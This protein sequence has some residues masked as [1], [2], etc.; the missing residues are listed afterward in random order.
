MRIVQDCKA[1]D[2]I[3]TNNPDNQSVWS[4]AISFMQRGEEAQP[5]W[6]DND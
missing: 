2:Y 6:V 3:Q 4:S 1:E 5:L